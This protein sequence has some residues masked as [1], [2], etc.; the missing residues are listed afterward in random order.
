MAKCGKPVVAAWSGRVQMVD[1]PQLG[2]QLRRHRR[3]GRAPGHGLHAPAGAR[4]GPQ[5]P[6]RRRR[7]SARPGRRHRQRERLPP[8]LRDLVEPR[9]TT[10]AAAPSIRSPTCAPGTVKRWPVD[11][12]AACR[13]RSTPVGLSAWLHGAGHA[14][15][16]V[17]I[18]IAVS[19]TA[20]VKAEPAAPRSARPAVDPRR[21]RVSRSAP[22]S[23]DAAERAA[24]RGRRPPRSRSV[25]TG[26][27]LKPRRRA[28]AVRRLAQGG[29][30]RLPSPRG[31][32]GR[33][34]S[35][36]AAT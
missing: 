26:G 7:R 24:R 16:V 31:L 21:S 15:G 12:H 5:G 9:A 34:R 3:L 20:I 23:R 14:P 1:Y 10:R 29:R 2:R 25:C 18:A 13:V 4:R 8:A 30:D 6:A 28:A 32:R 22:G 27:V 11:R 33:G 19:A 35:A 17:A 36:Q